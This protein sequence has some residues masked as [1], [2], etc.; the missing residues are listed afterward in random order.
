VSGTN[1]GGLVNGAKPQAEAPAV[2]PKR[3]NRPVQKRCA[4][5]ANELKAIEMAA[6]GA[7][8]QEIGEAIGLTRSAV[9]KMLHR[10]EKRLAELLKD[11]GEQIKAKQ[12]VYLET[13]YREAMLAWHES[14]KDAESEKNITSDKGNSTETTRRSQTGDPRYLDQARG[15][16]ADIRK[17]W[18]LDTPPQG[19][20]GGTNV[21][22]QIVAD[23]DFF[24]RSRVI[25]ISA[26]ENE[27]LA[28]L[29]D[30]RE[31]AAED[32]L[33]NNDVD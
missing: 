12:T 15:A 23:S 9:S 22:I 31:Q 30:S 27:P 13:L 3:P 21:R 32:D 26:D 10:T 11:R 2:R 8:Q 6:L 1:G 18:A 19:L 14:K 7:G 16:L 25:D 29:S 33:G 4:L 24:G 5:K 20:G 17:I 28:L